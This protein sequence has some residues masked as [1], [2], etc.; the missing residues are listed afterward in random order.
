MKSVKGAKGKKDSDREKIDRM[1]FDH[2]NERGMLKIAEKFSKE[3]GT[4]MDKKFKRPN[5]EQLLKIL[6]SKRFQKIFK[7]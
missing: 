5:L 4:D 7:Y 1:I 6:N 2:L 3:C